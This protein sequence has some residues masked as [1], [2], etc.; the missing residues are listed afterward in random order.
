MLKA[1][2]KQSLSKAKETG[3]E[4]QIA[5]VLIRLFSHAGSYPG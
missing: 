5:K 3:K 4:E 2:L 1:R